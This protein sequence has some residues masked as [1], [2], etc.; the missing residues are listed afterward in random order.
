[1]PVPGL[2]VVRKIRGLSAVRWLSRRRI[3]GTHRL[4]GMLAVCGEHVPAGKRLDANIAD[5][6]PTVLAGLGLPVPV[7]MEGRVL[8]DVFDQPLTVQYEPP[9]KHVIDE[10]AEQVYT[11]EQRETLEKR[12]ADLGY[13]E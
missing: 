8:S 9:Q 7:D 3:E 4:E 6:T 5:V 13:L 12:L 1:M 10:D 2:A 11:A